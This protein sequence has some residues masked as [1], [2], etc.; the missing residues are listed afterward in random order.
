MTRLT[1]AMSIATACKSVS[2]WGPVSCLAKQKIA[3]LVTTTALRLS[4]YAQTTWLLL[5][6]KARDS[7]KCLFAAAHKSQTA[8]MQPETSRFGVWHVVWCFSRTFLPLLIAIVRL[9]PPPV[10][11]WFGM[12]HIVQPLRRLRCAFCFR[13][14]TASRRKYL[15]L[16]ACMQNKHSP[17]F[18]HPSTFNAT[19]CA[20]IHFGNFYNFLAQNPLV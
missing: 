18:V 3:I 9:K 5:Q 7:H 4:A 20:F 19:L 10:P 8:G 6:N 12:L 11:H 2:K 14:A 1:F 17:L 15:C 13:E 16:S